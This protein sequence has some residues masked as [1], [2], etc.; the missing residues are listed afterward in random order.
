MRA[1]RGTGQGSAREQRLYCEG[2]RRCVMALF[3]DPLDGL[4]CGIQIHRDF[5]IFYAILGRVPVT[6]KLGLH[7]GRCIS[8]TLNNR[9]DY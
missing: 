6:I 3:A 2:H 8:A 1:F 9:L 4:N 5:E 7:V